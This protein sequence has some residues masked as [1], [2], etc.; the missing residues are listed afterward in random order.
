MASHMSNG[1]GERRRSRRRRNSIVSTLLIVVG[2]GL[3]IASAGIFGYNTYNYHKI[4]ENNERVAE[5]VKLSDDDDTPPDV[6][7]VALKAMNPDVVG[8]L[9]IPGT[10]VNYPVLHTDNNEYYLNHA[11]DRS[12]SIGGSVF[13]DFENTAP[14]MV[15]GQTIVYGHHMRNG[16]QFKQIADMDDQKLFDGIKTVWYVTENGV[17]NLE[18]LFLYYLNE[19]DTEVRQFKFDDNDALH[20]YLRS[21]LRV[22]VS[23]RAGADAVIDKLSHVLTLST[24]NYYDGYGRTLLVC[25]LKSEVG[26]Q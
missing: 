15:D 4:D 5:Y 9:R 18:P 19:N 20:E 14:G 6:D 25:A 11:P 26:N 24:C 8:W 10:I 2:V 3:L 21:Y 22:A 17:Y 7:W 23:K 16:S 1:S 12:D 13:M